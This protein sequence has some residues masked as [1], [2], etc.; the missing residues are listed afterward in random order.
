MH[1]AARRWL[2]IAAAGA[3]L[4][5]EAFGQVSPPTY[6]SGYGAGSASPVPGQL[7]A[8][9][10]PIALYPDPL[11]AQILTASTYPLEIVLADRWLQAPENAALRGDALAAALLPQSWDPSVKSLAPFA[12]ILHMMDENLAWTEQ[13][14]DAFLADQGAVMDSVQRLRRQARQSGNLRSTPQEDVIQQGPD[15]QIEPPNPDVL[16]IPAYDPNVVYGPWPYPDEPPFYFPDYYG[17]VPIGPY[18]FG[19]L[20]IAIVAPL[21]G[22]GYF[23]WHGHGIGVNWNQFNGMG[24]PLPRHG[25]GPWTHNVVHRLGVPYRDSRTRARFLG[26]A[27][28]PDVQRAVR[29]YPPPTAPAPR[30][31]PP[32]RQAPPAVPAP[33]VAPPRQE[34]PRRIS[35]PRIDRPAP[36]PTFESFGSRAQV[37]AQSE[38]GRSSMQPSM[39][40]IERGPAPGRN[41]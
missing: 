2:V 26:P 4:C 38:R 7:D 3:L 16:N 19:W 24:G 11:L 41:R 22:W 13:V 33:R 37:Q 31:E 20:S 8:L 28:T 32:Q 5:L 17:G 1:G 23:D 18:G 10:A 27:A 9:V 12:P 29:G 35:V 30:I 21:W 15:V 6:D 39:P 14:G 40:R 36:S 25:V 34:P